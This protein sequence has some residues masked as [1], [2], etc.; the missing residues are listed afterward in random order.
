MDRSPGRHRGPGEIGWRGLEAM[1]YYGGWPA[2]W[3]LGRLLRT[4]YEETGGS[5]PPSWEPYREKLLSD[6][7]GSGQVHLGYIQLT[8]WDATAWARV[9]TGGA[10]NLVLHPFEDRTLTHRECAR[11]MGFPD[12]WRILPN[13]RSSGLS[14]WWGKGISTQ[15]GKWIGE[16]VQRAI[17]GHPG[18]IT[19]QEIGEREYLIKPPR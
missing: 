8:R 3:H 13:R 5:L 6:N 7:K 11:I 16:Q 1:R 18:S 4:Y 2:G 9:I 10:L 15:C 19:G 12:N 17:E 14:L